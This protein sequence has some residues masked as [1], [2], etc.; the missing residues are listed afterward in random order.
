MN[1][2]L[3]LLAIVTISSCSI[4]PNR[5]FTT[6][7]DYRFAK[8]TTQDLRRP[9]IIQSEDKIE[10]HIY[11]NDGFKLIDI[12]QSTISQSSNSEGIE[13]LVEENGEIKLPV[14]GRVILKGLSINEA[15]NFLQDKYSKY[16][17]DPFIV[18]K[19]RLKFCVVSFANV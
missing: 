9:Y 7:K 10:L 8:D 1:K 17:K 13:Y 14:I 18:I 3:F 5:M 4:V 12:T 19:G 11:S 2:I 16:Y 15:E 6:P